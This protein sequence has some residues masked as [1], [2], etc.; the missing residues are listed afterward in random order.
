MSFDEKGISLSVWL[1]DLTKEETKF[2][3]AD[4]VNQLRSLNLRNTIFIDNTA[5]A[6]IAALYAELL[7]SKVHVVTSNKIAASSEYVGYAKLKKLAIEKGVQFLFETN[8]AAGLPVIR[9]M[10]DLLLTGDR[11]H[12]VQAV[13]SGTMN[14]I[15]NT[16]SD[17][18]SFSEAVAMA[19]EKKYTEPDPAIDLSGLDVRR[20]ALILA[21]EA[22]YHMELNDVNTEPFLD[23]ALLK[24]SSW[25]ELYRN[26]QNADAEIASRAMAADKKHCR[27]R[28]LA[29][30]DHGNAKVGL[31]EVDAT[32][33]AYTLSGS[34]NLVLLYT[35]RYKDLPL[36]IRGA[37]AGPAVTASGVLADVLRIV[38]V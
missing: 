31:Q 19:K 22:G 1:E 7:T 28:F 23:P 32:H 2:N 29:E 30:I 35:D 26:L 3:S 25:D 11:I 24:A 12:K 36:V 34:D 9:T 13:L 17:K 37:G 6:E 38:N 33:P 21:R 4:F 14:F 18:I 16:I 10:R 5:S 20:K 15:F 27:L 8:V